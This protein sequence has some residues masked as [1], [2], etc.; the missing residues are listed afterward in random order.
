MSKVLDAYFRRPLLYDLII[1]TTLSIAI[2]YLLKRYGVTLSIS[3][4]DIKSS[5]TDVIAT[6]I[7]LAGFVLTSLTIIITFKE[8]VSHK[9]ASLKERGINL[10][11]ASK[12]YK[13]IVG[14]FTWAV[15]IFISIF[16]VT[17]TAKMLVD[18]ISGSALFYLL[19]SSVLLTASTVLR[20]L[21]VLYR[22]IRLQLYS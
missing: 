3:A 17:A 8:N 15:V 7:S 6:S 20:S 1:V 9:E 18:K 10:L 5:M 12:H 14:I 2:H 16:F 19:L 13:T 22:V 4:N 21:W 11:L